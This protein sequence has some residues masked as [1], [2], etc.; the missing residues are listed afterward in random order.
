MP[1]VGYFFGHEAPNSVRTRASA[2]IG[3]IFGASGSTGFVGSLRNRSRNVTV[4]MGVTP[5]IRSL[6]VAAFQGYQV[7]RFQ[8]VLRNQ[9]G[10]I[11]VGIY[12]YIIKFD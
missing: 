7:F 3:Q 10:S 2:A 4:V 6:R 8:V 12:F 5:Q 1:G 9:I 11:Q